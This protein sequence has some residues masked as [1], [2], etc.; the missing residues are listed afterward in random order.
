MEGNWYDAL[1]SVGGIILH[2]LVFG[3]GNLIGFFIGSIIVV[4]RRMKKEKDGDKA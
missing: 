3:A 2:L 1:F 4:K